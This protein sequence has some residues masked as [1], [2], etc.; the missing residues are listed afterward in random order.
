MTMKEN[1]PN[2]MEFSTKSDPTPPANEGAGIGGRDPHQLYNKILKIDPKKWEYI[3]FTTE[4]LGN[5]YFKV[6]ER[7]ERNV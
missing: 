3:G 4:D 2:S 5:G 7:Y 1:K 6:I